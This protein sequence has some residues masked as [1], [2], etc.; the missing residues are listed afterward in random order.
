MTPPGS[1]LYLDKSD[2]VAAYEQA[3]SVLDSLTLDVSR[4]RDL[5]KEI[6]KEYDSA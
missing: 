6:A 1:W 5:L 3:W 4:S 2:E